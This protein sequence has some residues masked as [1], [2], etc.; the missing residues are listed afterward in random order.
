MST[1]TEQTAY[2]IE[3]RTDTAN[4]GIK[5]IDKILKDGVVKTSTNHREVINPNS[6]LSH[7]PVNTQATIAAFYAAE[8]DLVAA[9]NVEQAELAAEQGE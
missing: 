4:I 7:L 6:D 8:S 5:R 2:Q 1:Y 3:P 9:W